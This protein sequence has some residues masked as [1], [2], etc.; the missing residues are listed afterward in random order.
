MN[1]TTMVTVFESREGAEGAQYPMDSMSHVPP[2]ATC[3]RPNPHPLET[4]PSV[5]PRS[6]SVST[7]RLSVWMPTAAV[8]YYDLMFRSEWPYFLALDVL[9]IDGEDLRALPLVQRKRRLARIM[10]WVESRLLLLDAIPA[11]GKRLFELACARNLEGIVAKWSR[12]TYQCDGRGTSW[13]KIKNAHTA[14]RKGG[15]NSSLQGEPSGTDVGQR[16]QRQR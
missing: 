2:G 3:I 6:S 14:R 11:R 1:F 8:A 13:L 9:S 4:P 7:A 16:H 5:F 10:P 15:T 12:G